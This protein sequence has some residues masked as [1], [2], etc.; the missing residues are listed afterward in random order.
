[1]L[2]AEGFHTRH[3]L[4][5]DVTAHF[6]VA[7]HSGRADVADIK[8][9]F[10]MHGNS[11]T[12][13]ANILA[14]CEESMDLLD[15][16]CELSPG[17]QDLI[18]DRGMRFLAFGNYRRALRKPFPKRVLAALVVFWTHRFTLPHRSLLPDLWKI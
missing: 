13:K 18:R 8:A 7:A 1:M 12:D 6:K 2:L 15:L 17:N 9:S 11:G 10:R 16:L 4:F 3:H 5:D 14:W